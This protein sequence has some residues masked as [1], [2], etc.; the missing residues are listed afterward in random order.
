VHEHQERGRSRDLSEGL[1]RVFAGTTNASRK[2]LDAALGRGDKV[3]CEVRY[4]YATD[5]HQLF[6]PVFVGIR[7][8]KAAKQCLRDQLLQ[9]NRKVVT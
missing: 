6:Q 8:D 3:V 5:D 4:L 9:T 2:L 1:G 7:D